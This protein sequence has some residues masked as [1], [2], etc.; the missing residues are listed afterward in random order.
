MLY[1]PFYKSVVM[2]T[3]KVIMNDMMKVDA[4][5]RSG[6]GGEGVTPTQLR[7]SR[8]TFNNLIQSSDEQVDIPRKRSSLEKGSILKTSSF[9]NID[10]SGKA[11]SHK[12]H[13]SSCNMVSYV[14]CI[15]SYTIG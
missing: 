1:L 11:A 12:S 5:S 15:V 2:Y 4:T 10:Q 3:R 14:N 13:W 7:P 9:H 8:V 6:G